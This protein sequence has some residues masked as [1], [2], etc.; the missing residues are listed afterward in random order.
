M[1]SLGATWTATWERRGRG[2]IRGVPNLGGVLFS[3]LGGGLGEMPDGGAIQ[4]LRLPVADERGVH[5]A[6]PLVLGSQQGAQP[7]RHH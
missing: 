7:S 1:Y 5:G 3:S 6:P 2:G 4:Q